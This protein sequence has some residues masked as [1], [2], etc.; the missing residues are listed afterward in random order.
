MM[1]RI[2]VCIAVVDSY[3][4]HSKA[5]ARWTSPDDDG[6]FETVDQWREFP[7]R[8]RVSRAGSARATR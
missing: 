7:A 8:R 4:M 5:K 6:R 2:E 1:H 3:S